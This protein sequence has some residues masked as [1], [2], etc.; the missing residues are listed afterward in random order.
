MTIEQE[1][2]D[3]IEMFGIHFE[4][5]YNLPP[6]A[7]RI[8]GNLIIDGCKSG[9][10]FETLVEKRKASK[11]SVSTSLNLLFKLGKITY[12]TIPGDR[13]KYFKAS[14]FSERMANYLK[15][16]ESEKKIIEKMLV[17]REKTISCDEELYNLEN[18]K[19]YKLH[20]IEIEDFF[21]KTINKFKIAEKNN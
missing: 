16:L 17:Y 9:L 21:I 1:K 20:V 6:L 4:L 2:E 12:Y 7:S 5:L 8:L 15:I 10:T 13:K 3:L 11:S 14:P 19:T 18:A